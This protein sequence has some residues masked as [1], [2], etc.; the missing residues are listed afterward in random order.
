MKYTI[1]REWSLFGLRFSRTETPK[2]FKY[3]L[4]RKF[5]PPRFDRVGVKM[6]TDSI[7]SW[8]PVY[9]F[10]QNQRGLYQTD[11]QTSWYEPLTLSNFIRS[12][13][14]IV[15]K[16]KE[17]LTNFPSGLQNRFLSR[18]RDDLKIFFWGKSVR[19]RETLVFPSCSGDEN[20]YCLSKSFSFWRVDCSFFTVR[21]LF[22][23]KMV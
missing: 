17:S 15:C 8:D 21:V 4:L 22:Y 6:M 9:L 14:V 1:T 7:G 20:I 11:L 18:L 2:V 3:S 19:P 13:V 5:T 10:N 16:Y 12:P 23:L